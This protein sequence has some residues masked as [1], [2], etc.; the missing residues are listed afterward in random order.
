MKFLRGILSLFV[1]M[2][3]ANEFSFAQNVQN[4]DFETV[5]FSI[6]KTIYFGGERVWISSE[7]MQNNL[8]AESKIIYAELLDR[9]NESVAIAKI[10]LEGGKGFN[11]LQLPTNIPS[12]N[13]LLRIFTRISPYQNLEKGLVQ[14]FITVFNSKVSPT[15]VRE[16]KSFPQ[17][18]ESNEV[19]IS[20]AI[21]QPGVTLK[22]KLPS[23]IKI[24]EISIAALNPFLENE[25]L[26]SSTEIYE[27]VETRSVVPELYGHIIEAQVEEESADTT[28]LY[29]VSLHG[30]KSALFTDRPDSKG[31]MFF[32]AGGM[33]NWNYLVAQTDANGSL[34][35]FGIVS[36][37]PVTHFK[38]D[39]IFPE[40]Q[41][42][43]KDEPLLKELLKGGQIEGY[44]VNEFDASLFPVVTGFVE[45]RTY[46]LDDYTRFETVETVIK[47][48]V[49]EVS[50]RT[51]KKKK[52]FRTLNEVRSYAFDSNPLMLVDAMPVFDADQLAAFNPK[53]FEKLEVLTRS[54]YLN[55]EAFDG[56]MSF[57]SYKNDFG[58]FPIPSNGIYLD[59]QGILP[60]ITSAADLFEAPEQGSNLKDWRTVLY[61][62]AIPDKS[63]EVDSIE[64]DVPELVGKFKI[65]VT[66]EN[67]D[68][69]SYTK[70]FEVRQ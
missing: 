70:T 62:S 14:R 21:N 53:G 59:Y 49:P 46:L 19:V 17:D 8:P 27:A 63:V 52:Q 37:A 6:P 64:I 25:E 7:A 15:V 5:G 30:E 42:S 20:Q 33:K 10:P 44:F 57:I 11:F 16:R 24:K 54:F 48:Y 36:P 4:D 34:L 1:F 31:R 43:P 60:R 28:Q 55:E 38:K 29:Y 45:D 50:V 13:Y 41:I 2:S 35:D 3:F 51:V 12:D 9:Y 58:G 40:L 39:F 66:A 69:K 23:D 61:W 18:E 56:V 68:Q 67:D 32:D 65:I 22:I 26:I 47:E